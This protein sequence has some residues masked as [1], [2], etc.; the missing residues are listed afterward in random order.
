MTVK[1]RITL[2]SIL[3]LAVSSPLYASGF[4]LIEQS[5]TGLGNAFAGAAA[6][7]EDASTIFYNP[8]GLTL[9]EGQQVIGGVHM[10]VPSAK[11]NLDSATNILGAPLGTD[12]G[13]D[14]GS[15]GFV[16][17]LY[18]SNRINEKLAVGL[19]LTAPFGLTTEY[20]K[21]WVG[22][23]H[24][25]KSEVKT[26]NINPAIAYQATEKLSFGAGISAQYIEATLSSMVDGG[27]VTYNITHNPADLANLSDTDYDVL[28]ENTGD[29]WAFG[30]NL[31]LIYQFTSE[32]RIG[33][34]YRSEYDHN[35]KG[36]V[37]SDLPTTMTAYAA[38]FSAESIS[39]DITLPASASLSLLHRINTQWALM[40]DISWT[41][42]SSFDEMTIV[43][44]DGVIGGRTESTTPEHWNDT[45]R[46]SIGATY[47]P[48]EAL[49]LR[50][51]LA[52]DESPVSD[53]YRTPRIPGEDRI[54]I[55]LGAGYQVSNRIALDAAYVHIFVNDAKLDLTSTTMGNISGSYENSVD[56]ASVQFSYKF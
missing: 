1:I 41:Q 19:G 31:G 14:A 16:P 46:Y 5:V 17:N 11:F 6:S 45:W 54:W 55:S 36:D 25:V 21:T 51:G 7:A 27:L 35:L 52:Y 37:S 48:T 12:E 23:Y 29:D 38:A 56:I 42:W 20:D 40:A 3:L 30:F 43:F 9:L 4:A 33:V 2:L 13:G 24:A 28:V 49:T 39:S 10:V 50:T 8:A 44:E 32:T 26:I 34:S 18:Y 15:P 22:R 53:K 47:Q